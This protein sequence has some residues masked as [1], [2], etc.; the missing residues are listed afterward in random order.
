MTVLQGFDL[1]SWLK[2]HKQLFVLNLYAQPWFGKKVS[3]K[4]INANVSVYF[5]PFYHQYVH[6]QNGKI[7][8][9]AIPPTD[10][11]IYWAH[12]F[13]VDSVWIKGFHSKLLFEREVSAGRLVPGARR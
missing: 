9:I 3:A 10:W 2:T 5:I 7:V 4:K 13:L 1:F 12:K 6:H 11:M 8:R